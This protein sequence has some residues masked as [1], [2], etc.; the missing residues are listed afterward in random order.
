MKKN[1]FNKTHPEL[2]EG[3]VFIMNV[4]NDCEHCLMSKTKRIGKTAYWEDG[5]KERGGRVP[6]FI[7]RKE[8]IDKGIDPENPVSKIHYFNLP[9][10]YYLGLY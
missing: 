5:T 6:L 4:Y 3:E 10:S 2:E 1:D 9:I 8:L 7:E